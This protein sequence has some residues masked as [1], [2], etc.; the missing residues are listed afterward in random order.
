[1]YRT[2]KI[3]V[4][5][6]LLFGVSVASRAD[7]PRKTV[8]TVPVVQR[9]G[10]LIIGGTTGA[11]STALE[12]RRSSNKT[13]I[14]ATP[15]P[16]LGEDVIG[17][18]RL[19]PEKED[20]PE[21]P[22]CNAIYGTEFENGKHVPPDVGTIASSLD[23]LVRDAGISV[24]YNSPVLGHVSHS[25]T[26]H[27]YGGVFATENGRMA[28]CG[29]VILDAGLDANFCTCIGASFFGLGG[30]FEAFPS[31]EN[32]DAEDF[33]VY[34]DVEY[35]TIGGEPKEI[36]QSEF[37]YICESKCETLPERYRDENGNEYPIYLYR[38][39]IG[40]PGKYYGKV[41]YIEYLNRIDEQLNKALCGEDTLMLA[42]RTWSI[43]S[44]NV[45]TYDYIKDGGDKFSQEKQREYFRVKVPG[46]A[47]QNI[48]VFSGYS[49]LGDRETAERMLRPCNYIK[50]GSML[51][52]FFSQP[53]NLVSASTIRNSV[54]RIYH[55]PLLD[56]KPTEYDFPLETREPVRKTE[57]DVHLIHGTEKR[58]SECDILVVG[59]YGNGIEAAL[60]AA[61][62]GLNVVYLSGHGEPKKNLNELYKAGI[63]VWP[64]VFPYAVNLALPDSKDGPSRT[65]GKFFELL[66]NT[67]TGQY[68]FGADV[69]IDAT[70]GA[71]I[72][73]LAGGTNLKENPYD[74][75]IDGP[76]PSPGI[77]GEF[78]LKTLDAYNSRTFADTIF[79]IDMSFAP[80][81]PGGLF[82]G[83]EISL[84][85]PLRSCT[86]KKFAGVF[87][88]GESLSCD[89]DV[90]AILRSN[91]ILKELE[92]TIAHIA[93]Y[94][95]ENGE[96]ERK[97]SVRNI[98]SN[99]V[100][101]QLLPESV[102]SEMDN[103]REL[104]R[105]ISSFVDTLPDRPEN[106]PLVLW[107]P[108]K[109]L[110]L[111]KNA[112]ER[113]RE[114]KIYAEALSFLGDDSGLEPILNDFDPISDWDD[115]KERKVAVLGMSGNARI[116]EPIEKQMKSLD[117]EDFRAAI[118]CIGALEL[119]DSSKEVRDSLIYYSANL[120][121][122]DTLDNPSRELVRIHLKLA[123][124]LYRCGLTEGNNAHQL[125]NISHRPEKDLARYAK[126]VLE[127]NQRP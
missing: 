36:P 40:R 101:K 72:V 55:S 127:E 58:I 93:V 95:S 69:F 26:S 59:E 82:P 11:I 38:L 99:L 8:K 123:S 25:S 16:Y 32:S 75:L 70:V 97:T 77:N 92:K 23:K 18:L 61:K 31:E 78:V 117:G 20:E 7:E 57:L 85:I 110:G 104:L 53:G 76:L 50:R 51:G 84:S 43:P 112:F 90:A 120:S 29:D 37:P 5:V 113:D 118:I 24:Y 54:A 33:A 19:F 103:S 2:I 27:V 108:L 65:E 71:K 124:T 39:K 126:N 41:P 60:T 114:S 122:L 125:E 34:E 46:S 96:S 94:I 73:R 6:L 9:S 47:Q 63:R 107:D 56:E 121:F 115:S 64:S 89:R 116:I 87:V 15:Y 22:I 88:L 45:E 48:Y 111:L 44:V 12:V 74:F 105:N 102:L 68:A 119:T 79:K 109:S 67:K 106:L 30:D 21:G 17:T 83:K 49:G 10:V 100:R 14:I 98:Q 4:I 13:V 62:A 1:M 91:G 86:P 52:N 28:L 66:A 3:S 35:R 42:E 81:F 80:M